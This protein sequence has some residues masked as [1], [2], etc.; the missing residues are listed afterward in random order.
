ML[1]CTFIGFGF[2]G[3]MLDFLV[4]IA[5]LAGFVVAFIVGLGFGFQ[6]VFLFFEFAELLVFAF[7]ICGF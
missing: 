3:S 4:H 6:C 1:V 2:S 7:Q 5:I